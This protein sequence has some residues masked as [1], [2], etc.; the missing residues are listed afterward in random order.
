MFFI[1][2]VEK[3]YVQSRTL[4]TVFFVSQQCFHMLFAQTW[5]CFKLYVFK[6]LE[7][8][9]LHTALGTCVVPQNAIVQNTTEKV[10]KYVIHAWAGIQQELQSLPRAFIALRTS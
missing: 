1:D 7:L 3:S 4:K 10:S 2:C 6:P 9:L 8:R 5:T